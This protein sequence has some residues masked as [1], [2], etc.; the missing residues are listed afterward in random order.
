[1]QPKVEEPRQGLP[2]KTMSYIIM[3]TLSSGCE[4]VPAKDIIVNLEQDFERDRS[5]VMIV[6]EEGTYLRIVEEDKYF[7]F[8]IY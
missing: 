3:E 4:R 8:F 6:G 2:C 5:C 7:Y 1:M